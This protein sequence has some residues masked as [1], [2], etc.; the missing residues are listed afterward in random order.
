MAPPA[1]APELRKKPIVEL[2][3]KLDPKTEPWLRGDRKN[4]PKFDFSL[5]ENL[6]DE[7]AQ[8]VSRFS[9]GEEFAILSQQ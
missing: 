5:R 3:Y 6:F 9:D 1:E 2:N 7:A 4:P 8:L